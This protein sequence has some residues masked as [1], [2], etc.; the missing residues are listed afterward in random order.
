MPNLYLIRGTSGS[1]KTTFA[2]QLAEM[3]DCN[4]WEADMYFSHPQTG[5]YKFNPAW[6]GQAHGWCFQQFY[7]DVCDNNNVIVSNTFTKES[8]MKPYLDLATEHGYNVVS[9]VMENRHG[10]KSVHDVPEHTLARQENT[11]R[12][13]LKF[14]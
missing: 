14:R 3:L 6:I 11:L 13:N 10:N 12:Q 7:T 8:D 1:G 5:E 2:A 9:L 4:Y